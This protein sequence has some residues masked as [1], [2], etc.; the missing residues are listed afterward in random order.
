MTVSNPPQSRGHVE[1]G[2]SG[3]ETTANS[4]PAGGNPESPAQNPAEPSDPPGNDPPIEDPQEDP[5][6]DPEALI[7]AF[8]LQ[9]LQKLT[10]PRD[11]Q[12]RYA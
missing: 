1:S 5:E 9:K 11:L 7:A 2:G 6:P 4:P 10:G 3:G 8:P 12:D